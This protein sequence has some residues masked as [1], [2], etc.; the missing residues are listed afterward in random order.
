ML[1]HKI[2]FFSGLHATLFLFFVFWGCG[3]GP[4]SP[5]RTVAVEGKLIL[6]KEGVQI[7]IP[8]RGYSVRDNVGDIGVD[9]DTDGS[10]FFAVVPQNGSDLQFVDGDRD[11]PILLPSLD[12]GETVSLELRY[13]VVD[14][15]LITEA[16]KVDSGS[17]PNPLPTPSGGGQEIPV[18]RTPG[19]AKPTPVSNSPFDAQ[20][21]TSAFGIPTGLFGNISVGRRLYQ[22]QCTS[23]HGEYGGGWRFGRLKTRIGQ[24]PMFLSIPDRDLANI[25]AYLNI[26][27]R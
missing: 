5:R 9:I 19:I 17:E 25:T 20:G 27:A 10:F 14:S 22:Q 13:D 26:G 16:I 12:D 2:N 15:T 3:V 1:H 24:A 18:T 8:D 6:T 4:D 11:L 23:C 21:T 7:A